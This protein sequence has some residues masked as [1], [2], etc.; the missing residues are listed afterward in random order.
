MKPPFTRQQLAQ[1]VVVLGCAFALKLYYS[2]ASA[3]ELRWVLAPTTTMVEAVSGVSFAFEAHAGYLSRERGFLIASSCAGVN[4]LLT[5][6]LLLTLGRL[7]RA[8]LAWGFIP[9]A[10]LLAYLVTLVANTARIALALWLLRLP[11]E[12]GWLNPAQLHRCAGIVVYFGFLLLLFA[13]SE[14]IEKTV[15]QAFF[16]LLVYY[17]TMLGIPLLHRAYRQGTA[18]WEHS[19]AVLLV[20]LLLLLP[21][22]AFRFARHERV[23]RDTENQRTP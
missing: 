18:F 20:P 2:T 16:P 12:S 10:A 11:T 13:V 4:F 7:W 15:G 14:R 6:F 22:A 19:L 23:P 8:R 5:A 21:L 1:A 3:D 9:L 17:A